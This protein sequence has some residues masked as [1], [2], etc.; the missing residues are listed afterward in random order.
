MIDNYEF[1]TYYI[2]D[3]YK[4]FKC[5]FVIFLNEIFEVNK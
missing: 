4:N 5:I 3:T 2:F 1:I